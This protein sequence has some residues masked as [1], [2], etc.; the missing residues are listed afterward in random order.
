[1]PFR[2]LS[3]PESHCI[4]DTADTLRT[5]GKA[6]RRASHFAVLAWCTADAITRPGPIGNQPR[7]SLHFSGPCPRPPGTFPRLAHGAG[8]R[9]RTPMSPIGSVA[10]PRRPPV[11]RGRTPWRCGLRTQF[12]LNKIPIHSE[13]V[14]KAQKQP[15]RSISPHI[16]RYSNPGDLFSWHVRPR[17]PSGAMA[18]RVY[19]PAREQRA[20]TPHAPLA[21]KDS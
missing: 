18:S 8:H 21:R 19:H 20:A 1:M 15:H 11:R 2:T 5:C 4:S 12:Y 10:R 6:A 14:Y 17:P 13:L 9:L 3:V 7:P 16:N